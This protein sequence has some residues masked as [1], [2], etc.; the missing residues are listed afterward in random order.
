MN[1]TPGE[2]RRLYWERPAP[3]PIP[4]PGETVLYR[5]EED[6]DLTPVVVLTV[7]PEVDDDPNMF[8]P[9]TRHDPAPLVT[10]K[11]RTGILTACRE[12]RVPG[13][14]GWTWPAAP[15]AEGS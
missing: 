7:G 5:H 2:L 15:A 6:G 13:Q 10:F 4:R 8:H 9:M 12:A 14:P 3:T 11:D 1:Y